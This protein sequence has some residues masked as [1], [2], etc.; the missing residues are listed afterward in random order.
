MELELDRDKR[1]T[2]HWMTSLYCLFW[3]LSSGES[4][5][6]Q[7]NYADVKAGEASDAKQDLF[8]LNL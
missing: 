8:V 7:H 5:M 1:F 4:N 6:W 3:P 2:A